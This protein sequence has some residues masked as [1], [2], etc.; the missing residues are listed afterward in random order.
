M[1]LIVAV[2]EN[3]G[4]GCK[5][6]LLVR[7]PSDQRMFREKTTGNVVV[8]GRKTLESF[9]GSKPLKDRVNIVLTKENRESLNGEVIVHSIEEALE[10]IKKYP[11]ESIYII[12]GET[13]YR[14]F[15]PYCDE[16]YVTKIEHKYEADAHFPNL[17][18]DAEWKITEESEEQTYFD[19]PYTFVKYERV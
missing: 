1:K 3:W 18:Q 9:P 14:Q 10:E 12:G 19:I 15:L 2:D 4:I 11:K 6:E 5:N 8:M 13:I 7:I 16:A 17:D